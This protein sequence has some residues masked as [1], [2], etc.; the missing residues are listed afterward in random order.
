LR[1]ADGWASRRA[2]DSPS[3]EHD[4]EGLVTQLMLE[5][6]RMQSSVQDMAQFCT[7]ASREH[8]VQTG[9]ATWTSRDD[10]RCATPQTVAGQRQAV[11]RDGEGTNREVD[12]EVRAPAN[13]L[14]QGPRQDVAME[15]REKSRG[16][17]SWEAGRKLEPGHDFGRWSLASEL[18]TTQDVDQH[19]RVPTSL[20][21]WARWSRAPGRRNPSWAR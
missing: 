3:A 5:E 14:Q 20:G 19:R 9:R 13:Q 4:V 6:A 21:R 12:G 7:D 18:W 1:R 11:W 17:M 16:A 10:E 15:E 8:R 2:T